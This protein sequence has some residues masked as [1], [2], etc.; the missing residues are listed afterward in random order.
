MNVFVKD[1]ALSTGRGGLAYATI[2][3]GP[4]GGLTYA[5][6][7]GGKAATG[8][9]D[10]LAEWCQQSADGRELYGHLLADE[11]V[12]AGEGAMAERLLKIIREIP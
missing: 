11:V 12:L 10:T 2:W 5:L 7:V 3:R 6:S 4:D 9:L 8:K 1:I